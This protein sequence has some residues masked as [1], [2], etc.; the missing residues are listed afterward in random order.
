MHG[1]EVLKILN[2]KPKHK[3]ESEEEKQNRFKRN[4]ELIEKYKKDR[5]E[6]LKANPQF[7]DK[8]K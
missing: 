3:P 1:L 6:M 7:R 8:D 2:E 4:K 5:E